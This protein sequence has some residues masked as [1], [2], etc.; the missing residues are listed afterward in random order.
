MTGTVQAGGSDAIEASLLQRRLH[1]VAREMAIVMLRSSRSPIWNEA[2]DFMTAVFD[3]R[4][5]TLEQVEYLPFIA[6]GAQ[7]CLQHIVERFGADVHP[8]DVFLHN[9][10]FSGSNQHADVGVFRPVFV[11]GQLAGWVAAKGHVADIGGSALGGYNP[12]ITEVWQEA[13]RIPPVRVMAG[14]RLLA[15]VWDLIFANIRLPLVA[16]DLQA[17]IGACRVGEARL[18][19]VIRATGTEVFPSRIEHLLDATEAAVRAE[20]ST[21]PDGEYAASSWITD[22]GARG[23]TGRREIRV[24]V[25]VAGDRVAFDFTGTAPQSPTYMNMP[26]STT[27]GAALLALLMLTRDVARNAGLFRAVDFVL[28]EGSLVNPAFPAATVY[29]NQMVD[30]VFDAIMRAMAPVLPDRATAG[31]AWEMAGAWSGKWPGTEEPYVELGFFMEKGGAG[32][33]QVADGYD[34]IGFV[35]CAGTLAAQD[36][37]VLEVRSPIRLEAYGL[38]PDSAGAGTHRGGLGVYSRFVMLGDDNTFV[39]VGDGLG[40]EGAA[41]FWGAAGGRDGVPNELVVTLADGTVLRPGSKSRLEHLGPGTRIE[42]WNGGGG[43]YGPPAGRDPDRL[44][45][46]VADQVVSAAAAAD[47]EA[48]PRPGGSVRPARPRWAT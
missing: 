32:A 15:D 21:F 24:G 22:G 38:W 36:P 30:H 42:C 47:Y 10:V 11:D 39:A 23:L 8:G 14:D 37:E 7:P 41:P 29:G 2:K 20:V 4:G 13:L 33:T 48:G 17:A 43:G 35:G 19:E 45:R 27:R 25:R 31:W 9:D 12:D 46:D 18:T 28:P 44:A 26:A 1:A 40:R 3:A 16:D 34:N 6:L 5:R